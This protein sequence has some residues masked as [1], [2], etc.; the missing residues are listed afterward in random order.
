MHPLIFSIVFFLIGASESGI[1]MGYIS[2]LL[3]I[4]PAR[5]RL[6]SIGLMHTLVAPTVF[7]SVLGGFL[8]Q[9]FS[10]KVLFAVVAVTVAISLFVSVKLREPRIKAA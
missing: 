5:G 3:E 1:G 7:F 9:I 8:G 6:I 2:Y 4:S 10:F